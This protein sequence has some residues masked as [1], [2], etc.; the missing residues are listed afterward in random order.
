MKNVFLP[1]PPVVPWAAMLAVVVTLFVVAG[2][3]GLFDIDPPRPRP[4]AAPALLRPRPLAPQVTSQ[5]N[6]LLIPRN[7]MPGRRDPPP[8]PYPNE[9][10]HAIEM[11]LHGPP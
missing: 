5:G 8:D 6:H 4:V 7:Q 2:A 9:M 1:A 11:P 10:R 3:M